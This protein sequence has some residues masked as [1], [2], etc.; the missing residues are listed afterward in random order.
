MT[1]STSDA[2]YAMRNLARL[3]TLLKANLW[4]TLTTADPQTAF[5]MHEHTRF[6][7]GAYFDGVLRTEG[8]LQHPRQGCVR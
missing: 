1:A 3:V 6:A 8:I 4:L 7:G 5:V 2:H